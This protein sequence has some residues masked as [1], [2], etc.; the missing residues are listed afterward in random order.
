MV[1]VEAV[2]SGN[3]MVWV[4]VTVGVE[5]PVADPDPDAGVEASVEPEI[6]AG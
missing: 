5:V 1:T 6:A 4:I 2:P 3:V